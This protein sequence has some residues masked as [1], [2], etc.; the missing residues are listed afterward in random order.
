MA[1]G[2]KVYEVEPLAKPRMTR[3]DSWYKPKKHP[4]GYRKPVLA[5][6]AYKDAIKIHGIDISDAGQRIIFVIPVRDTWSEKKKE[7]LICTPHQFRPDKDNLEKG[8]FDAL[9]KEDS[10]IWHSEVIKMW[11]PRGLIIV[12]QIE[13]PSLNKYKDVL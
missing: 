13:K 4:G 5:W 3:S 10:H 1:T 7:E 12:E 9:F 2:L 11:G 6:H 8:L